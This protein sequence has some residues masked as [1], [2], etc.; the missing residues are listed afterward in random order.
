MNEKY[1]TMIRQHV[2]AIETLLE[3]NNVPNDYGVNA[4]AWLEM[5]ITQQRTNAT[6]VQKRWMIE[7]I[8]SYF[9]ESLVRAYGGVWDEKRDELAIRMVDGKLNAFPL[10]K[11]AKFLSA[12]ES[13]SFVRLF[14]VIPAMKKQALEREPRPPKKTP[15]SSKKT[16]KR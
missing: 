12:G 14:L 15:T 5:Y 4:L 10:I 13:E 9:G 16:P 6:N 3:Q 7:A 11:V 1:K 2:Q 8:G